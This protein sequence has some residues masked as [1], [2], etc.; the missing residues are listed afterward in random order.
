LYLSSGRVHRVLGVCPE[1]PK[2]SQ[3]EDVGFSAER[4]G[5][6]DG[7]L[8]GSR[9]AVIP[10]AGNGKV[11]YFEAFG[12]EA[13]RSRRPKTDAIFRIASITQRVTAAA[14]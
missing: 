2:A 8:L 12:F 3:P 4:L 6:P 5:A 10:V 7:R 13:V 11:A 9:G 14:Q 1:L